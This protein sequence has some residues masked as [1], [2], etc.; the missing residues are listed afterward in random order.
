LRRRNTA[1]NKRFGEMAAGVIA[2]AG[3]IR[4]TVS[5]SP[6]GVQ[7]NRHFAKPPLRYLQAS[8]SVVE[9]NVKD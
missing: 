2:R 8:E 5:G 7:L 6:S 9:N 1:G 3:V 4:E